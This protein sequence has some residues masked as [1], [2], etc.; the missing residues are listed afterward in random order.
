M[1]ASKVKSWLSLATAMAFVS[2]CGGA[3]GSDARSGERL[4]HA[5]TRVLAAESNGVVPSNEAFV[6][7]GEAGTPGAQRDSASLMLISV[8]HICFDVHLMSLEEGMSEP[9]KAALEEAAW[10]EL[11]TGVRLTSP[12]RIT[13]T[14]RERVVAAHESPDHPSREGDVLLNVT[15][16]LPVQV[17]GTRLCF[18]HMGL[19]A[20]AQWVRLHLQK[21]RT[22]H[23][24]F[25]FTWAD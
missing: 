19:P 16:A 4:L 8:T 7:D 6:D 2:A 11:H 17:L 9:E 14:I 20:D 10:L 1:H 12:V 15:Q 5:R 23:A 24:S 3:S 13:E 22:F 21:E 18:E 25:E